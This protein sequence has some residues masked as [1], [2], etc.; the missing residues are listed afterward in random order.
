M[1]TEIIELTNDK[2]YILWRPLRR[3]NVLIMILG[4]KGLMNDEDDDDNNWVLCK[5]LP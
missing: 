4:P 2:M 3:I 1:R 5:M